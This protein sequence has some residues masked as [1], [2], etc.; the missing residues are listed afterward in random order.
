MARALLSARLADGTIP[1]G[2]YRKWQGPHW[3]LTHLAEIAYP[4]GDAALIPMRDQVLDWQLS[5]RFGKPPMTQLYADQP[6][7]PR[8]CA[9]MEG[10]AIYSQVQL[11]L[12]CERTRLLRDRLLA[13][14]WPDG[15]WNCDKRR[16]ARLSS[17]QET[18]IPLRG[19]WHW[20]QSQGDK[21]ARAT[22]DKAAE[23]LLSRKLLWRKRDGA[24]I[25]PDWGGA[26]DVI[27]WPTRFYDLLYVLLVMTELGRVGDSRCSP[28]L[29]LLESKRLADGGFPA[30]QRTARTVAHIASRG[31]FA[32]WGAGNKRRMNPFVTI[33]ALYVLRQAGR[34]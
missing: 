15:G 33:D 30:E 11:G 13:Y 18:L 29:D 25:A 24:P 12:V 28:A 9:S 14:Q 19:L 4:P 31:S 3:T 2:P 21:Q 8:R 32:D 7:R 23:L 5:E 6:E 34:G 1:N 27:H 20:S 16:E 22:V 17:V 10:N 26:V